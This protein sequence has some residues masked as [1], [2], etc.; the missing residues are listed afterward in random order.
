MRRP[1]L[2]FALLLAASLCAVPAAA[3]AQSPPHKFG[4]G[5]ANLALG[6][7]E[8]PAQMVNEGRRRGP[9]WAMSRA[10][11]GAWACS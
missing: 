9:L 5:L 3:H 6:I 1:S 10:S 11:R 8:L 7:M 2:P 4:R